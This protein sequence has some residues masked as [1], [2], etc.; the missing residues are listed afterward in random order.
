[1]AEV[2][3]GWEQLRAGVELPFHPDLTI[4]PLHEIRLAIPDPAPVNDVEAAARSAVVDRLAA[5]VTPGMSVAVGGGSRGLSGRVE[6]LRGTIIGLRELGAKP[7]VVPAMGSHGGA[8]ADGQVAMMASLGMTED[9]LDCEIRATMETVEVAR[10]TSGMPLYLDRHA[11]EAD[12]ILPVNRVKPHTCFKGSI[13]SGCTKMAVVGFGKQPGAAQIHSCGPD[14]M[15]RRLLD[16]IDSLRSTGRL[17]GGV[18]SVESASGR[19]VVVEGLTATDVGGPAETRLAS[20]SRELVPPLP[21]D[22]IDVLVI[23][24]AGKDISGTGMDPNVTGR[25]W[26]HGLEDLESPNVSTIVLLD[27]TD[28][29]GGNLLGIGLADFVPVSLADKI[30][31]Q[32]TYVNC[33]TAGPSGVRRSR[34]P[35]VLADEENCMKA[36]LSMCGVAVN[37]PKRVVR[38]ESTLHLTRCWVSEAL[39]GELPPGATRVN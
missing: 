14:E 28:V 35:M 25:F 5:D 15:R 36:A 6:L 3:S 20:M 24:K 39:I 33:F 26:V 10:T 16:G 9:S 13:E 30:D 18:A 11:A 38:I 23:E 22:D 32:K 4:P 19:V 37:E 2:G 17:L 29:S 7:F 34:M 31:W 21:F 1:M 8:T 12:R 27:I